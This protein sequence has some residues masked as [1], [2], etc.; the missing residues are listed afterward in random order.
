MYGPEDFTLDCDADN[1]GKVVCH[2]EQLGDVEG[3]WSE[4]LDEET[5]EGFVAVSVQHF[6]E[7]MNGMR[8]YMDCKFTSEEHSE[9]TWGRSWEDAEGNW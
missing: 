3:D 7:E 1:Q 9:C 5:G 6:I 2:S 4:M 8:V